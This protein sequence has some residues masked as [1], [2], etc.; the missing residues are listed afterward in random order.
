M[1][2]DGRSGQPA[3]G[4]PAVDPTARDSDPRVGVPRGHCAGPGLRVHVRLP[5]ALDHRRDRL[6]DPADRDRLMTD[7]AL[8]AEVLETARMLVRD[9]TAVAAGEQVL[10]ITDYK[11]DPITVNALAAASRE[12]EA[13]VTVTSMSPRAINGDPF[14]PL[15][16]RAIGGAD[17]VFAVA[18]TDML[19]SMSWGPGSKVRDIADRQWRLVE[20]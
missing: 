15:V 3:T 5:A 20:M 6:D 14:T 8:I 2:T 13:E 12:V 17:V 11:S 10:V 4:P 16:G 19:H 7:Q 1:H 18:S 9:V